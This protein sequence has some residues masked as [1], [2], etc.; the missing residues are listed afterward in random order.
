MEKLVKGDVVVVNFY[1]SDLNISKRRPA[2][3]IF[4]DEN[5]AILAEITSKSRGI[6]DILIKNLDFQQGSLKEESWLRPLRLLTLHKSKIV[7]KIGHLKISKIEEIIGA[8]CGFF[9]KK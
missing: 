5:E 9:R 3:V 1:F 2:F 4:A 7:Y 8:I 6:D